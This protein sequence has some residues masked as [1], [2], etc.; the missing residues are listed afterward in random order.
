LVGTAATM[1]MNNS[2]RSLQ[3]EGSVE[4]KS[5]FDAEFRRFSLE[6]SRYHT[7]DS[8]RTHL[9]ELHHLQRIPFFIKYADPKVIINVCLVI[10]FSYVVRNQAVVFRK[11]PGIGQIFNCI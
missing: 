11:T 3:L 4:V 5:K 9:C 7:Y 1:T 8:F 2:V 10:L 6:K